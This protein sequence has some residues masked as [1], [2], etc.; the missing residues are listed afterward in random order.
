MSK[1]ETNQ[2]DPATGTTLTLGTSGDTITIPSGVTI[3]N[4]GTATGFG[5]TMTP[6]FSAYMSGNTSLSNE[7]NTTLVVDTEIYDSGSVFDTSNYRFTPGETGKYL[8]CG[9]ALIESGQN[10][11]MDRCVFKLK[12][13][14]SDF[15]QVNFDNR[16]NASRSSNPTFQHF[17]NV[18]SASDYFSLEVYES[19]AISGSGLFVQGG[20][21]YTYFNGFKIIE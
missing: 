6:A 1:L 17:I 21:E 16:G 2:V 19:A 18:T 9:G 7:T 12:K 4:S 3:A 15:K 13:N 8:I 20:S 10:A 14:G 11:N 5:G